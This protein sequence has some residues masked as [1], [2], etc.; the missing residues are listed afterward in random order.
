MSNDSLTRLLGDI[1]E[2]ASTVDPWETNSSR[3]TIGGLGSLTGR[4]LMNVGVGILRGVTG[5]GL[6]RALVRIAAAQKQSSHSL[7]REAYR[8]IVEYQR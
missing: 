1:D 8:D 2:F 3:S 6:R 4:G 5:V 7:S